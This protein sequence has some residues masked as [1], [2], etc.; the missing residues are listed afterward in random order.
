MNSTQI[1]SYSSECVNILRGLFFCSLP[2]L[3]RH[4]LLTG[5]IGVK[6][7][8][9]SL[10]ACTPLPACHPPIIPPFLSTTASHHWSFL[11]SHTHPQSHCCLIDEATFDNGIR[12]W[13]VCL[14]IRYYQSCLITTE[15]DPRQTDGFLCV[16][17]W[18]QI[19][20]LRN[21]V[22]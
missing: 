21:C 6:R 4:H 13:G 14:V 18:P 20:K 2:R 10:Q 15:E 7:W 22:L 3:L 19:M 12:N 9:T 17:I 5:W 8:A 11:S 1:R 16:Q